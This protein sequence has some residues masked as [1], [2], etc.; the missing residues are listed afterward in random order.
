MGFVYHGHYLA[1]FEMARTELCAAR[2]VRYREIEQR[3][4]LWLT[5]VGATCRYH[6]PAHYDDEVVVE[7]TIAHAHPRL[8]AFRYEVRHAGT[9]RLLTTGE[10]RHVFVSHDGRPVKVPRHYYELFA[11]ET[12]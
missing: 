10:T 7:A 12:S 6:A 8:I 2:G 11:I 5:V 9:N 4:H 1:W 3:D